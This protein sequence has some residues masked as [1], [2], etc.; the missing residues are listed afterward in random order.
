MSGS[1]RWWW[2]GIALA[3]LAG[4][5]DGPPTAQAQANPTSGHAITGQVG[6]GL[7]LGNPD[8]AYQSIA[9]YTLYGT[10]DF[11]HRLGLDA[12]I[13]DLNLHTPSGIGED[14]F[15]AG[16]RYTLI[17]GRFRPYLRVDGGIGRFYARP[18]GSTPP[19]TTHLIYAFGTGTDFRLTRKLNLR[20]ADVEFQRWPGYPPNGLTPT[21]GTVGVAYQ[22]R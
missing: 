2:P 16:G 21:V 6:G 14:S 20:V 17:F 5:P 12:E 8:F 10:L 22:F 4:L 7:G 19:V 1:G 11:R 9:G 13:H 15:L 3:L 18:P